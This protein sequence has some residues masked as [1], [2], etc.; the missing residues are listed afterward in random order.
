MSTDLGRKVA[1]YFFSDGNEILVYAHA[2]RVRLRTRD[3][4]F[5]VCPERGVR[6]PHPCEE[7]GVDA[8]I[9]A[10]DE[11]GLFYGYEMSETGWDGD[12]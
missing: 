9:P 7:D 6:W 12:C 8:V 1:H 2:R 11:V 5:P 4:E 3:G 10:Y